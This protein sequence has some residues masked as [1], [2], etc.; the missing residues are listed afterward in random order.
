M[1]IRLVHEHEAI[2]RVLRQNYGTR[3]RDL[4]PTEVSELWLYGYKMSGAMFRRSYQQRLRAV[5][6]RRPGKVAADE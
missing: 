3:V 5:M 1:C 2:C 6:A 4:I